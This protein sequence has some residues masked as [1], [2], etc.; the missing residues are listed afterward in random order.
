M[1]EPTHTPPAEEDT[2]SAFGWCHWHQGHADGIRL[3]DV[4]EQGSGSGITHFACGP[5]IVAN[6]L[7]PFADR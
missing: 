5:C 6:G 4:I 7:V 3:I 2:R 1:A